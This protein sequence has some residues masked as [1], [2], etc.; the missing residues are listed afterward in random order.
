MIHLIFIVRSNTIKCYS[1]SKIIFAPR[2]TAH[3]LEKKNAYKICL[4]LMLMY[5]LWSLVVNIWKLT[6]LYLC[7]S[8]F[9]R[10][11]RQGNCIDIEQY[12][13]IV[14]VRSTETRCIE[15][16]YCIVICLCADVVTVWNL[17]TRGTKAPNWREI[18]NETNT[19]GEQLKKWFKLNLLKNKIINC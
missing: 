3:F 2:G 8:S 14:F 16:T 11:V 6:I 10:T 4:R 7:L 19:L 13:A 12:S 1:I 15:K 18:W 9:C 5:L 17:I